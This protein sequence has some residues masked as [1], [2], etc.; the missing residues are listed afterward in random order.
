MNKEI[1]K[2]LASR[3]GTI[4]LNEYARDIYKQG[5]KRGWEA[6]EEDFQARSTGEF[7]AL[8]LDELL[9]LV[10]NGIAKEL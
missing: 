1:V 8:N 7:E 4:L 6:C 5:V 10:E 3:I 9:D 2:E